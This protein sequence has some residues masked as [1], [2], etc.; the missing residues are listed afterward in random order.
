MPY[1]RTANV[2]RRQ[3]ARHARIVEA[4]RETAAE[5]G[6]GAV[7]IVPVARRA[8]IASG[9]VYRYFPSKA[10]L[11]A[12]LVAATAEQELAALRHAARA[13]PGPVSAL[14]AVI[15]NFAVRA[16]RHRRLAWAVLA[17]PVDAEIAPARVAYRQA[18]AEELQSR[19]AA[20]IRAGHLP[21]QD[22]ALSSSALL[23]AMLEGLLGP[24]AA[25]IGGDASRMREAVQMLTLLS[26]RALGVNDARARGL[27]VQVAL[28]AVGEGTP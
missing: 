22:L 8:G 16:L 21:H 17:E 28:P 15:A 14:A 9:T 18:L 4:A 2:I 6:I 23:G 20:A 7:Q 3:A 12:A 5:G 24:L 1:R 27:V 25:E 11:V 10:D 19:I 26:L 13:A